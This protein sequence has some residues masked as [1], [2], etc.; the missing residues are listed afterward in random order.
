MPTLNTASVVR[1]RAGDSAPV[2]TMILP[3]RSDERL[4][5]LRH[6]V[7]AVCHDVA[8]ALVG[9]D[10]V[11]QQAAVIVGQVEAVLGKQRQHVVVE[12]GQRVSEYVAELRLSD[13]KL[14]ELV[15]VDLVDRAAG[16]DEPDEHGLLS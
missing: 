11:P 15:E 2:S 4:R 12:I 7:R 9:S 1:N 8:R 13:G 6:R 3:G 14:T 16:G 5:R 10:R